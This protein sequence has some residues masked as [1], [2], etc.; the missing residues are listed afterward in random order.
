MGKVLLIDDDHVVTEVYRSLFT[1]AGF[2][3][4]T[5]SDGEDGLQAVYR[6]RPDAVLL[7]LSMPRLNGVQWLKQ[8]RGDIRFSKLPVVVFTGGQIS[9]QVQAARNSD[10]TCIMS[11]RSD[12]Q[13]V[14]S[15]V[16]D[17]VVTGS[18]SI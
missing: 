17:A 4:S 2:N 9:W 15:A 8:V 5:A 7:D 6:D 12:P 14:V 13:G 3:V 11:K 10:V 18:W 16:R 1:A